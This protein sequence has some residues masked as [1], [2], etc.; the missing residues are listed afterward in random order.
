[1]SNTR[2]EELE[3]KDVLDNCQIHTTVF[4]TDSAF[5]AR[6]QLPTCFIRITVF[7]LRRRSACEKIVDRRSVARHPLLHDV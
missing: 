6:T 5:N 2:F 4:S 3:H 1:M 7:V